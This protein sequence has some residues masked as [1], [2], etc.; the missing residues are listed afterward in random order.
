[1]TCRTM[2]ASSSSTSRCLSTFALIPA[3]DNFSR[4]NRTGP[5][6]SSNST[7]KDQRRSITDKRVCRAPAFDG[8]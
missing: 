7:D 6:R 2:P 3:M 1:M 4:L 8:S 5:S